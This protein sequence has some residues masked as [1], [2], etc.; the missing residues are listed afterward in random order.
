[1]ES[2]RNTTR[3]SPFA[4]ARTFAF[5]S[6]YRASAGQS[7]SLVSARA[8]C[9]FTSVQSVE[10]CDGV[11]ANADTAK[12]KKTTK[13]SNKRDMKTSLGSRQ[14]KTTPGKFR[15]RQQKNLFW[16]GLRRGQ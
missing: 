4:G 12:S 7:F 1:M 10:S 5:S 13:H 3:F 14:I 9:A 6:W 11:C 8:A 16:C 2:P 15:A